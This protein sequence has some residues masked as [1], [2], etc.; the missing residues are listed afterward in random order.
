MRQQRRNRVFELFGTGIADDRAVEMRQAAPV[1]R[2]A[3][4]AVHVVAVHERERIAAARIG[5]G[6]AGVDRARHRRR[7]ARHDFKPDALLVQEQRFRRAAVV[8]PRAKELAEKALSLN[9]TIA[10]P[11]ASL[12]QA[13]MQYYFDWQ[14]AGSELDRALE[15]EP[16]IPLDVQYGPGRN[17]GQSEPG[18][19]GAPT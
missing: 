16:F 7:H 9:E 19:S 10:E 15:R 2:A 4:L 17:S 12:G 1:D 3:R 6:D 18:R 8:F 11:H 13:L 14:R 5:D